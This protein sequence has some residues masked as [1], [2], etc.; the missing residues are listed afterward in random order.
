MERYEIKGKI[1]QGGVGAV[2]RAYD[3][4]LNRDVAIKRILPDGGFENETDA[5]AHLIK[6]ANSLSSIQHPHIVTVFDSGVDEDGPFVVMELLDGR[7][8]DEMVERSVLTIEDF[9]E[10]A[11]QTQE[12]LVAAQDLNLV[13]RDLK[14]SNIM[15]TWLPSGRFQVKIVDFGL[16]KFSPKPSLQTIDHGDSVFGSIFFMAP[17]QFERTE[18][19]Q[20]T[21]MY[22]IGCVYYF[23]LTGRYPF[24]GETAAEVM[25]AHLDHAVTPV[26]EVREDVPDWINDWVMWHINRDLDHRPLNAREALESFLT[27]DQARAAEDAALAAASQPTE[28]TA[29]KPKLNVGGTSG[30]Q[31]ASASQRIKARPSNITAPQPIAPPKNGRPSVHTSA[32]QAVSAH[33][34]A[35]ALKARQDRERKN[36]AVT[37][38]PVS[39]TTPAPV[40]TAPTPPKEDPPAAS[41]Y[42]FQRKQGVSN[43]LKVGIAAA[44][45]ALIIMVGLLIVKKL[46]E[47]KK[48]ERFSELVS[49]V[50]NANVSEVEVSSADVDLLLTRTR[51]ISDRAQ[52]D[53]LY[54]VLYLAKSTDGTNIDDRVRKLAFAENTPLDSRERLL[55]QVLRARADK[56]QFK[57]LT[58]Y[59][60]AP[61][62]PAVATAAMKATID[63]ASEEDFSL[64][65][66]IIRDSEIK[67]VRT[68]AEKTA[69][70][71]IGKVGENKGFIASELERAY[72]SPKNDEHSYALIRLM[73]PVGNERMLK[74][75]AQALDSEKTPVRVAALSALEKWPN[76]SAADALIEYLNSTTQPDLRRAAFNSLHTIARRDIDRS[77]EDVLAL[78]QRI[79]QLPGNEA[80][81]LATIQQLGNSANLLVIPVLESFKADPVQKVA[82]KASDAIDYILAQNDK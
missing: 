63:M 72:A 75:I 79:S 15:V 52:R 20:R 24:D 5:T 3:I 31:T 41:T 68:A 44:L 38:A 81:K 6:E 1:G 19:D 23:C 36:V 76:A 59:V 29:R 82:E 73:G 26:K 48:E 14:P 40:S 65:L 77:D 74:V 51:N 56:S 2:Y 39:P 80:E 50:N 69:S 55:D 33:T 12:A 67:N 62:D 10:V 53:S 43:G 21:D 54:Q 16:A 8:V 58:D 46:E 64:L 66:Q 47:R 35:L 7:T 42:Q 22:A 25:E 61:G 60:L 13:H 70:R 32:Q 45:I 18:L 9:K 28:L 78:W 57:P 30:T 4:Q 11:I 37:A 71:L 17:E 27:N 34:S 49:Q